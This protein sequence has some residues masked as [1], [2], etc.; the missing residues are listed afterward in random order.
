MKKKQQ[1]IEPRTISMYI[2][3]KRAEGKRDMAEKMDT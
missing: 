1:Q 2:L 3:R